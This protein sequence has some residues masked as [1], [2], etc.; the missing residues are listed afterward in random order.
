MKTVLPE[1]MREARTALRFDE[2][3]PWAH[4]TLGTVFF[5]M[6]RRDEADIAFRRALEL[7]PNFALA[8]ACISVSLASRGA[9]EE[10]IAIAQHALRL[11]PNDRLVARYGSVGMAIAH[12]AAGG[13]AACIGWAHKAIEYNANRLSNCYLI[14]AAAMHGDKATA[15]ATLSDLLRLQP[16]M[17]LAWV[18]K[19]SAL[20]GEVA[21]RFF[22]GLRK[23]GLPED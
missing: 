7:N 11:S 8:Q 9:H 20:T 12:F 22:E 19:N 3:D 23:A 16:N 4:L 6:R 14:A 17:S 18:N 5:R 15:A 1:A 21:E 2:R 13:Y 10:A